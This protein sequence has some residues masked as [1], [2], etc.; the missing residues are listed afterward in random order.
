MPKRLKHWDYAQSAAYFVTTCTF[1]RR[2]LFG[3]V[4]DNVVHHTPLGRLAIEQLLRTFAALES[5][6]PSYVVMPDHVHLLV[7]VDHR[8]NAAATDRL[9]Q[10]FKA[11]VTHHGRERA[12]IACSMVV[13]QRGFFDRIVRTDDEYAALQQYIET[14]P[15]RWTLSR[16]GKD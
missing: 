4:A 8:S 11:R 14:N 13:W 9:V 2:P 3:V 16:P 6:E 15:L 5:F 7:R 10:R 12:L 1:A